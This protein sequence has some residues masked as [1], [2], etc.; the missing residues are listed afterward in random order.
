MNSNGGETDIFGRAYGL[1]SGSQGGN[2]YG[3]SRPFQTERT[4]KTFEGID[5]FDQPSSNTAYNSGPSMNLVDSPSFPSGHTTY[6]YTGSVLLAVLV[7]ERYSQLV[8]RAAEYGNDRILMGSHYAMDVV[9]GRTLALYDMAHLLAN[10]PAYMG[11]AT[12][13]AKPIADFQQAVKEARE[14]LIPILESGCGEKVVQCAL[15]DTGRFS[16]ADANEAFY[17]ET[18]TYS[19]PAVNLQSVNTEDVYRIAPEAGYLLTQAFPSLTLQEADRILTETEGPGGG[20]MDNGSAF[21]VYS[22][23]DLYAA[24]RRAATS[25][26]VKGTTNA[27]GSR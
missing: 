22:R 23:I 7:P 10:D 19:L 9:A 20:F 6:G 17:Q 8:A 24:S 26:K 2:K 18:Q 12:K 5:Y 11:K 27:I 25:S 15:Q 21:G 1:T 14:T 16:R 13:G 4:I 3:N